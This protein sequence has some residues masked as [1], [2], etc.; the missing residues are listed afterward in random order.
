MPQALG[1]SYFSLVVLSTSL[2]GWVRKGGEPCGA[3][4]KAGAETRQCRIPL[5]P[6]LPKG[7]AETLPA[8]GRST[9]LSGGR[10]PPYGFLDLNSPLRNADD[11]LCACAGSVRDPSVRGQRPLAQAGT[12][13][14]P[15]SPQRTLPRETDDLR[16]KAHL[17]STL[18]PWCRELLTGLAPSLRTRVGPAP[19]YSWCDYAAWP[20][21]ARYPP[22]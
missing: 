11:R 22:V 18:A 17:E 14:A 4:G 19:S 20:S 5:D 9:S 10:F 3:G 1:V 2:A 21:R 13:T 8:R 12:E 16:G 15:S 7:E 6:P